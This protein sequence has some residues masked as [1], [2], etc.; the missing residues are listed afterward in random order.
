MVEAASKELSTLVVVGESC[1]DE[2]VEGYVRRIAPDAPVLVVEEARTLVRPGAAA[3]TAVWAA[4]D[5]GRRHSAILLSA[6]ADDAGGDRIREAMAAEGVEVVDLGWSGPTTRKTRIRGNGQPL[7][8]VDRGASSG[9]VLQPRLACPALERA[10]AVL[11]SD[12]GRGLTREPTIRTALG[13]AARRCPVVWDPHIRGGDPVAGV[14]VLTPNLTELQYLVDMDLEPDIS[15]IREAARQLLDSGGAAAVAVT[16]SERGVLLVTA[17]AAQLVPSPPVRVVDPCGAGDR[18]A[19]ALTVGLRDGRRLDEAVEAAVA[20]SADY[21]AADPAVRGAAPV[22]ADFGD[23]TAATAVVRAAHE[24]GL[25]IVATSGCFD[26]IHPGHT[27]FLEEARGRGDML[28]VLLNSDESVRRIKGPGRPIT[29]ARDRAAV[30]R[31]LASVDIVIPF[32]EDTPAEIL[33]RIRPTIFVKGGDYVAMQLPEY[34][35]LKE[36]GAE[37]EVLRYWPGYSTTGLISVVLS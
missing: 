37:V 35:V 28:V 2:D 18:F 10:D 21:V 23:E 26:L 16:M 32:D 31:S 9:A 6:L 24:R 5:A 17:G 19:A 14:T 8:R 36:I 27:R 20:A 25:R 30:L 1:L 13:A 33:R 15:S 7:L 4:R 3:H 12:Y 34:A 29:V 11:V 22:G